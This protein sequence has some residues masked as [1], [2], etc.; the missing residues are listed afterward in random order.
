[1]VQLKSTTLS[2]LCDFW[3]KKNCTKLITYI[4]VDEANQVEVNESRNDSNFKAIR[5]SECRIPC[6]HPICLVK[7]QVNGHNTLKE[8]NKWTQHTLTQCK[9]MHISYKRVERIAAE[10][11]IMEHIRVLRQELLVSNRQLGSQRQNEMLRYHYFY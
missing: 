4:I 6:L 1:M 5:A 8:E 11:I 9:L 3:S 2:V 7:K 10:L